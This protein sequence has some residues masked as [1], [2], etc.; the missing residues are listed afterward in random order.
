MANGFSVS[1]LAGKKE[2]MELGGLRHDKE[3]V[4]LLSTTHGAENHSLAT[5][6]ETMRIYKQEQVVERL[7]RQGDRVCRGIDEVIQS[8][9]GLSIRGMN[10][11]GRRCSPPRNKRSIL[12]AD[13]PSPIC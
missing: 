7:H 9:A 8:M 1:A 10:G 2:I 13:K 6:I 3:R 12:S 11:L 4:F 5:V